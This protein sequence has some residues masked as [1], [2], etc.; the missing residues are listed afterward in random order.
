MVGDNV[1]A[2]LQSVL[3]QSARLGTLLVVSRQHSRKTT[4]NLVAMISHF[5]NMPQLLPV[6]WKGVFPIIKRC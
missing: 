6:M 5:S 1:F 2:K 3:Q 4:Q